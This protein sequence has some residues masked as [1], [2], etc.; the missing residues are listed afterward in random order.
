M[1]NIDISADRTP[2]V[3]LSHPKTPLVL[4]MYPAELGEKA[5]LQVSPK[6][7]GFPVPMALEIVKFVNQIV[8]GTF[9][10]METRYKVALTPPFYADSITMASTGSI[11]KAA[12]IGTV[13]GN[14]PWT[15]GYYM[16]SL[17]DT[18]TKA[19]WNVV[20]NQ[21][22]LAAEADKH[23]ADM[24]HFYA[25]GRFPPVAAAVQVATA[26]ASFMVTY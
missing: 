9:K 25:M 3:G 1:F 19:G 6:L 18:Y 8:N 13:S 26:M 23:M 2:L 20:V 7:F 14:V 4:T 10:M 12:L 21:Q 5:S 24:S 22:A 17:V 15:I 16:E 11:N